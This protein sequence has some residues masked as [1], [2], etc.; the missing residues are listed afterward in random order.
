MQ[1]CNELMLKPVEFEYKNMGKNIN[2]EYSEY[3][4]FISINDDNIFTRLLN[5]N[6][7]LQE[8]FYFSTQSD[9]NWILK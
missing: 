7:E 2:T 4:P 8:D 1:V 5:I 9:S 3:L 6:G